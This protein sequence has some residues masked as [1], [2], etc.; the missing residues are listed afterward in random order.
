MEVLL[1]DRRAADDLEVELFGQSIELVGHARDDLL[2]SVGAIQRLKDVNLCVGEHVPRGLDQLRRLP[3]HFVGGDMAK[4]DLADRIPPEGQHDVVDIGVKGPRREHVP[5]PGTPSRGDQRPAA[6][7]EAFGRG[8]DSLAVPDDDGGLAFHGLSGQ[9]QGSRWPYALALAGDSP[10]SGVR[11]IRA[12]TRTGDDVGGQIARHHR[13]VRLRGRRLRAGDERLGHRACL[14]G[15][16]LGV[17]VDGVVG[18]DCRVRLGVG[19]GRGQ[20][21]EALEVGQLLRNRLRETSQAVAHEMDPAAV[22]AL[23]HARVLRALLG[24]AVDHRHR[25]RCGGSRGAAA[26]SFAHLGAVFEVAEAT[27]RVYGREK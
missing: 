17:G 16:G 12:F 15:C 22:G 24:D 3:H 27:S 5:H 11:L 21:P 1:L 2:I 8:A 13:Q 19:L 25:R 14:G 9:P 18:L 10:E 26:R 20:A 7:V 4:V 6:R 23:D